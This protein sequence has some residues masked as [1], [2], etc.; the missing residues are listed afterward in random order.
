MC[1]MTASK[2]YLAE[3]GPCLEGSDLPFVSAKGWAGPERVS[4][5]N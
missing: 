5:G 3:T 2:V 4:Q 1:I